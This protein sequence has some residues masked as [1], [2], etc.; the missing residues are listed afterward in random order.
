VDKVITP[1]DVDKVITPRVVATVI[2]PQ[3]ADKEITPPEV[4]KIITP[5]NADQDYGQNNHITDG[6]NELLC[7]PRTKQLRQRLR[8]M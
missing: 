2:S 7:R 5:Q 1:Q 3:N 8:T 4:D 6:K